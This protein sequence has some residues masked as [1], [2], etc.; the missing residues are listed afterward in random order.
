[1][2]R[3]FVDLARVFS[4]GSDQAFFDAHNIYKIAERRA[5]A[6]DQQ[7]FLAA[8]SREDPEFLRTTKHFHT[9]LKALNIDHVFTEYD[10]GHGWRY[11]APIIEEALGTLLNRGHPKQHAR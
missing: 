7:I 1:M 6:F 11:W 10:G 5:A 9:H 3:V 8:G 4:D 2:K